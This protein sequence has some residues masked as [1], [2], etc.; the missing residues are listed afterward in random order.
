MGLREL[1]EEKQRRTAKLPILVGHPGQIAARVSAV[2]EAL[3]A[4]TTAEEWDRRRG[5]LEDATEAQAGLVAWVDVRSLPDDQWDAVIGDLDLDEQGLPDLTPVLPVL[6]AASC[7]E[8]QDAEWWAEQL[9]RPEWTDDEKAAV[10]LRL[11]ELNMYVPSGGSKARLKQDFLHKARMDYCGPRG[12]EL[13]AFL[14]WSRRSQEAALA[15]AAYEG[16]RCKSC[17]THPDEWADD[18]L[19]YHAHLTDCRGCKQ[20]HRLS[21][22]DRAKHGDGKFAV[23]AGGSPA[24]CR[25]CRPLPADITD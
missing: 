11:L 14:R 6:L 22:T 5:E 8:Q 16:R 20:L 9:A 7:D 17:G 4:A 3:Q 2:Q 15:W 19:A 24:D 1:I 25:R 13:D 18:K 21:N 10:K 23:M 12:I